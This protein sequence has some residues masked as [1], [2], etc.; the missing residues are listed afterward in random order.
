[1]LY[2][3]ADAVSVLAD[4]VARSEPDGRYL[5]VYATTRHYGGPEEGGWWFNWDEPILCYAV[6]DGDDDDEVEARREALRAEWSE[7]IAH[8]DIYSV[9]DGVDVWVGLESEPFEFRSVE[10]PRY[11]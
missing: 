6:A 10:R 5:S 11:S 4:E 7:K 9:L 1:M 3:L 2:E 8:G